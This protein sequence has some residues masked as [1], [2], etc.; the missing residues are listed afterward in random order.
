MDEF[1]CPLCLKLLLS[2][3]SLLCGHTFCR[4]CIRKSYEL[5]KTC[6]ICRA[7]IVSIGSFQVNFM[8][9]A[10]IQKTF[11]QEYM[12]RRAEEVEVQMPKN[13]TSLLI[14]PLNTG[15]MFPGATLTLDIKNQVLINAVIENL[16]YDKNIATVLHVNGSWIGWLVE[17]LKS[18][19]IENKYCIKILCKERLIL[20]EVMKK[21]QPD[22]GMLIKYAHISQLTNTLWTT[23]VSLLQ[24]SL[25][26]CNLELEVKMM[27]FTNKCLNLLKERE[28]NQVNE[29]FSQCKIPSFFMLSVLKL[30]KEDLGKAHMSVS[31][32]E[33]LEILEKFV[34]GKR[35]SKV[36]LV[37]SNEHFICKH[38]FLIIL[39]GLL[40]LYFTRKNPDRSMREYLL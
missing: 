15:V 1:Q 22:F 27:D 37:A 35:P 36:H 23:R 9:Q 17:I 31:E 18:G 40:L 20:N 33:R 26:E 13:T 14:V 11:P 7:D 3:V 16:Q 4:N 32:A 19:M 21:E 24:D 8:I 28:M 39:I 30:R 38:S 34:K 2:P 10:F 6:P 5:Y 12:K 25:V 29:T